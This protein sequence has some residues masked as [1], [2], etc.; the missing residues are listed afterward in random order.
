[1]SSIAKI[2][3][4]ANG[5]CD[6]GSIPGRVISKTIKWYLMPLC[7]TL[8]NLRYGS[9]VK[10]SNLG[11]GV[12]PPLH[13]SVVTKEKETSGQPWLRRPTYYIYTCV[14]VC[15]S[16]AISLK[17]TAI[18]SIPEKAPVGTHV[19]PLIKF[20]FSRSATY[21][22]RKKLY[23][24]LTLIPLTHIWHLRPAADSQS[25]TQNWRELPVD[26]RGRMCVKSS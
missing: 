3:V 13:L 5:P 22:T 6:Q 26:C 10:W 16:T 25:L 11:K 21:M 2:R 24:T 4:F 17:K 23:L 1:M 7:L 9:T 19:G 15:V 8:S 12:P 18:F 14:F 20:T